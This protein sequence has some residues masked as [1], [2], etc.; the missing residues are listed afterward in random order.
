MARGVYVDRPTTFGYGKSFEKVLRQ[1]TEHHWTYEQALQQEQHQN[2]F[3]SRWSRIEVSEANRRIK[4]IAV[5]K[6]NNMIDNF[7]RTSEIQFS[8]IMPINNT[9]HSI[10][11]EVK[12]TTKKE[13]WYTKT[14]NT[15]LLRSQEIGE[16]KKT[17]S[18]GRPAGYIKHFQVDIYD[19]N[20]QE[21][22]DLDEGT[23]HINFLHSIEIKASTN[24]RRKTTER[25][26]PPI[27][28]KEYISRHG[29]L[30][31]STKVRD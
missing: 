26:H 1:T 7:N 5:S 24:H 25:D 9:F 11:S 22:E 19:F 29:T 31:R 28:A 16:R 18:G 12:A 4:D 21:R 20:R 17:T 6:G 27:P 14:S 30:I 3:D 2:G 23:K 10:Q 13:N 8:Q 15:L